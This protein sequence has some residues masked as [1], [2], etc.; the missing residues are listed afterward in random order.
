MCVTSMHVTITLVQLTCGDGLPRL[1]IG[2]Q[3]VHL[4]LAAHCNPC[5]QSQR[6]STYTTS[7][8]VCDTEAPHFN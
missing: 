8:T 5:Q 4:R 7:M 3:G 6:L 1:S 2:A